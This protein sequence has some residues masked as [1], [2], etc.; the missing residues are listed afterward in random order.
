MIR[1]GNYKLTLIIL[2]LYTGIYFILTFPLILNFSSSFG[3]ADGDNLITVWQHWVVRNRLFKIDNQGLSTDL[4]W[5]PQSTN[6]NYSING[7]WRL[8]LDLTLRLFT[9]NT[10]FIF[11]FS[12]AVS[13][14]LSAFFTFMLCRYLRHETIPSFL[15]GLSFAFSPYMLSEGINHVNLV[16]LFFLPV[17][18]IFLLQ[19][20][21]TP[22]LFN[23]TKVLVGLFLAALGSF[24]YFFYSL[25]LIALFSLFFRNVYLLLS[26]IIVLL[27]INILLPFYLGMAVFNPPI[28]LSNNF[29]TSPTVFEYFLPSYLVNKLEFLRDNFTNIS[30]HETYVFA[31]WLEL[32][33]AGLFIF[34]F[35]RKKVVNKYIP[36]KKTHRRFMMLGLVFFVLS[37]GPIL[38]WR[39]FDYSKSL[40]SYLPYGFLMN[41][42]LFNLLRYPVRLSIFFNFIIFVILSFVLSYLLKLRKIFMIFLGVIIIFERVLYPYSVFNISEPK[43]F[44]TWRQAQKNFTVMNIPLGPVIGGLVLYDQ[45]LHGKNLIGGPLQARV[46]KRREFLDYFLSDKVLPYF[47]CQTEIKSGDLSSEDMKQFLYLKTVGYIVIYKES[48]S[49]KFCIEV[50]K[51]V[52]FLLRDFDTIYEDSLRKILIVN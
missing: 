48:L 6:F 24:V 33:L 37:L 35:K 23:L 31:G 52:E 42:P 44:T 22:S 50:K 47:S 14:I 46:F 5:Y 15:A 16:N 9:S 7:L 25:V 1:L 21:N 2:L 27:L 10:F 26:S 4:L 49:H 18:L 30:Y 19:Y 11:N 3:G 29:D 28:P 40:I 34:N 8:I 51:R 17:L 41:L 43:I 13:F 32:F 38:Q 45:T 12:T 20:N 36:L 39:T